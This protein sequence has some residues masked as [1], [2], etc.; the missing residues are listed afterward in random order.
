MIY[1]IYGKLVEKAEN[2]VVINCNGMGFC[3]FTTANIISKLGNVGDTVSLYTYL[4]VKEDLM[5]LYGFCSK[6]ELT[7][8]KMLIGVS[9]VGAK[10]ALAILSVLS[11]EDIIL[12]I[13]LENPKAFTAAHGVG[14]KLAQ[15]IIL[16]LKS[17][18]K[19]EVYNTNGI[20]SAILPSSNMLEALSALQALGYSQAEASAAIKGCNESMEVGEIIKHSLK[21]LAKPKKQK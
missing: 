9:G 8:F 2:F 4:N 18:L 14:L 11:P 5:E 15:R 1:S 6:K 7:A 21:I 12:N 20:G 17:K 10:F 3:C 16:E 19:D 13:K